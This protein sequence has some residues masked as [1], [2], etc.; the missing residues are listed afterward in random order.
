M[1]FESRMRRP[2]LVPP[3]VLRAAALLCL[4]GAPLALSAQA[5]PAGDP[6]AAHRGP[7]PSAAAGSGR[8]TVVLLVRHAEKAAAPADDPGLSAAGLERARALADAAGAAGV[9][10]IIVTPRVRTRATAQP[11][12]DDLTLTPE[13]VSLDGGA[14]THVAAVAAAVRRHVGEV[15]LVVGHSNTIPAIVAALGGP[16]GPDI[17]DAEYS[18]LFVLVLDPGAPAGAAAG[19]RAEGAHLVRSHYGQPDNPA[20]VRACATM[21]PR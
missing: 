18:N 13:T 3:V 1:H 12:A 6:H 11:L 14:A 4:A 9:Q 15:V 17:C 7:A 16:A 19:G 21:T 10:A 2:F 8:A 5:A 20:A